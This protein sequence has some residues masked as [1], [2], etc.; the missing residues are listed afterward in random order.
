MTTATTEPTTASSAAP[1]V[2]RKRRF[3][4]STREAGLAYLLILPALTIFAIFIFYPF[5]KNFYLGF[6]KTPPFPGLPKRFVGLDQYRDVLTSSDFLN[7]LRTT[8]MFALLTV[9]VGHRPRHRLGGPRAP[10]PQGHR[11]LP[12]DLLVDGRHVGGGG[13][14]DLRHAPQ[15]AG[16]AAA[17]ARPPD[18]PAD[19]REPRRGRCW[20]WR[21]RRS[22][23]TSASASS[24][25]RRACRRSPTSCS[26]RRKSTGPD[27]GRGSGTSR[28]PCCRRRSSSP[29]SSAAI[30]AFQTFGQIDLLTQGG[31]LK[32]TNVLTYFIY[33]ELRR[34]DDGQGRRARDRPV[35]RDA[36][37][38]ADPAPGARTEGQL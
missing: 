34:P 25:C 22:G 12:D 10:A 1:P 5:F 3:S 38:D 26:R 13:V 36:R 21:S 32:K 14:G 11:R 30:F 6:Y 37:A 15:P 29:S 8:V 19:P 4:R 24:S 35:R 17:L 28:C 9:P 7:S 2:S 23:R 33:T 18:R 16:R 31:P 27:R 20:R